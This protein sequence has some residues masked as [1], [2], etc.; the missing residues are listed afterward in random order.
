MTVSQKHTINGRVNKDLPL[1]GANIKFYFALP[2]SI[3]DSFNTKN[4][5]DINQ[6]AILIQYPE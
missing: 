6:Y 2:P 3:N 4:P 5:L 1:L